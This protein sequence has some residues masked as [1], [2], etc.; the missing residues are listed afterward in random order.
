M[1]SFEELWAELSQK[2]VPIHP[3]MAAG[4][5]IPLVLWLVWR[6]NKRIHEKLRHET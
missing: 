5:L 1:K 6:T 2:A 4:A 3:E